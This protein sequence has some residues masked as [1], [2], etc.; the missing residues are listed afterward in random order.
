MIDFRANVAYMR[1]SGEVELTKP[2]QKIGKALIMIM[3]MTALTN[4]I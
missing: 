2:K 3:M 1:L 4:C